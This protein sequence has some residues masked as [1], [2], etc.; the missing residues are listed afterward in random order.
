MPSTF[1]RVPKTDQA[2][3]CLILIQKVTWRNI[4]LTHCVFQEALHMKMISFWIPCIKS[5]CGNIAVL[6]WTWF[7]EFC[8]IQGP[9]SWKQNEIRNVQSKTVL[10]FLPSLSIIR[11]WKQANNVFQR[12]LLFIN[13]S[14][15]L[16]L[17]WQIKASCIKVLTQILKSIHFG[18]QNI[19]FVST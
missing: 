4:F 12:Y 13:F 2:G 8:F 15:L 19:S 1:Y 10:K 14:Y 11:I 9:K 18:R 6:L 16:K 17:L 5:D 7:F 3:N